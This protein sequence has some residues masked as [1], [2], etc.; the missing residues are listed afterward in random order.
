L[1]IAEHF[2]AQ[3]ALADLFGH[4]CDKVNEQR[5]YRALDML[6]PHKRRLEVFLKNRLGR[7]VG[8]GVRPVALRRDEHVFRGL[9]AAKSAGSSRLILATTGRTATGVHRL[10]VTKGGMPLGYESSPEIAWT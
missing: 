8:A 10:V 2:Y 1:H 3:S 7:A 6:L 4:S 5:L 9:G